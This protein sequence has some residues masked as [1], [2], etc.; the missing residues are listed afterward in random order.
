MLKFFT[1]YVHSTGI[2]GMELDSEWTDP[3]S[4]EEFTV[5]SEKLNAKNVDRE[6]FPA[7]LIWDDYLTFISEKRI[8]QGLSILRME[9]NRLLQST[10]WVLAYDNAQSLL[11]LDDWIQYR[12]SL[13]DFF[14]APFQLIFKEG[15]ND[16]D[17][18]LIVFP[19]QPP[20][21]RR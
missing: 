12:K 5:L 13:R 8:T 16:V 17:R 7:T 15:T 9:R 14:E 4:Q 20:I 21:M 18:D 3:T 6:K 11:N 10:D 1:K 19:T 2:P